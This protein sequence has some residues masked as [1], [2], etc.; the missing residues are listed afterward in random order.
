MTRTMIPMTVDE[1]RETY[2]YDALPTDEFPTI[3]RAEFLLA[4]FDDSSETLDPA[5]LGWSLAPLRWYQTLW[6]STE[7][8]AAVLLISH[9]IY[10]FTFADRSSLEVGIAEIK[11]VCNRR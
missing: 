2:F 11:Q 6:Y 4:P 5:F 3:N 8:L 1:I 9:E 10:L 7:Q